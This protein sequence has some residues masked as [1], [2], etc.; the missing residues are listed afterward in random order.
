TPAE[1]TTYARQLGNE[2][3]AE[4]PGGLPAAEDKTIN[5]YSD[6]ITDDGRLEISANL[7]IVAGEKTRTL[8]ETLSAPKPHGHRGLG[9]HFLVERHCRRDAVEDVDHDRRVGGAGRTGGHRVGECRIFGGG[10]LAGEGVE[11]GGRFQLFP[12]PPRFR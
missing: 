2:L 6:R 7:D 3:A 8:M 1:I 10:D 12:P 9:R 5:S 11:G 4:T